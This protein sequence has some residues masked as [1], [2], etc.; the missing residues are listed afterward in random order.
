MRIFSTFTGIGG[1]ELGIQRAFNNE[2][3]YKNIYGSIEFY[4]PHSCDEWVIGDLEDAKYFLKN[5]EKTIKEVE[6]VRSKEVSDD[7]E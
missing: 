5:L 3:A 2:H 7:K 4:L 6:L 1:F